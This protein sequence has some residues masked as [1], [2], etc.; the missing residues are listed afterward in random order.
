MLCWTRSE[1]FFTGD[2]E[3]PDAWL[4]TQFKHTRE[5]LDKQARLSDQLAAEL[6]S[7]QADLEVRSGVAREA[8]Q[9]LGATNAE[10]RAAA[11]ASAVE[12]AEHWFMEM[13]RAGFEADARAFSALVFAS[14]DSGNVRR[15]SE[16]A[17]EMERRGM[18]PSL[19][20]FH[21]ALCRCA[22]KGDAAS[23]Q[24]WFERAFAAGFV[25]EWD[26]EGGGIHLIRRP[27]GRQSMAAGEGSRSFEAASELRSEVLQ[28]ADSRGEM[29]LA[30]EMGQP[31]PTR[32]RNAPP[33]H[34]PVLSPDEAHSRRRE[35]LFNRRLQPQARR[36]SGAMH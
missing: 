14:A 27:P 31:A 11:H 20:C 4:T 33:A 9:L 30:P 25:P 19:A 12:R 36:D 3:K 29:G 17:Q 6:R 18:E 34:V 10:L 26:A 5:Q 2:D 15:A 21:Y 32:D 22:L 1:K 35:R 24:R 23:A 28:S 7:V 13:E 8:R 16:C